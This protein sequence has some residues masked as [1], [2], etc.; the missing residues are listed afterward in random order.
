MDRRNG[1]ENDRVDEDLCPAA[2]VLRVADS[3]CVS[4]LVHD[5]ADLAVGRADADDNL[6]ALGVTPALRA[7]GW[8]VAA[9]HV[10][11]ELAAQS[12]QRHDQVGV[13][14]AIDRLRRR[15]QRHGLGAGQ[16]VGHGDVKD[17]DGAEEDALL[18]GLLARGVAVGE[19]PPRFGAF[20]LRLGEQPMDSVAAAVLA[21]AMDDPERPAARAVLG[22][23]FEVYPA[24]LA[25]EEI[26]RELPSVGQSGVDDAIERLVRSGL[27]HRHDDFF[28][29]TRAARASD[30]LG[31]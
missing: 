7:V 6:L 9:L 13:A 5:C 12:L 26:R 11:A 31:V 27:A 19:R 4:E 21:R 25:R 24:Q 22:L 10:V 17:G 28:W 3:Q 2:A 8:Q 18:A 15:R 30:E 16:H 14:V 29:A 20:E 1:P 23:L